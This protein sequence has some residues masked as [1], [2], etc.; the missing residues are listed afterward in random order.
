MQVTLVVAARLDLGHPLVRREGVGR[1]RPARRVATTR[2]MSLAVSANRRRLPAI[3]HSVD[4]AERPQLGGDPLGERPQ[5]ADATR[6]RLSLARHLQRRPGSPAR[7]SRPCP[8][9]SRMRPV[10]GGRQHLLDGGRCRARRTR[11]WPSWARCRA[12]A[13]AAPRPA[14]LRLDQLLERGDAGRWRS[15]RPTL[16]EIVSP[17]ARQLASG[18]PAATAAPPT[19]A[20][21]A[22]SS[23]PAG[24][25]A[26]GRRPRPPAR[27][28]RPAAR[29]ARR[30]A[31]LRQRCAH[32]PMIGSEPW[33]QTAT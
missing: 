15:A 12:R 13:S 7:S 16:S 2:S 11:A 20:S 32:G 29:T 5:P 31:S 1:P 6:S 25:R 9:R 33:T 8:A 10:A 17:D 21:R 3:S 30:L 22:A 27:A 4:V 19:R 14:A 24:R 23:R 26:R 28:G 18:G